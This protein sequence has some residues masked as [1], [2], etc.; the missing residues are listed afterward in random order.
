[1]YAYRLGMK[2]LVNDVE[3]QGWSHLFSWSI[4]VLS[5]K[6][7]REVYYNKEVTKDGS[8]NSIVNGLLF[9]LSE[10]RLSQL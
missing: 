5:E 4:P 10:D 9:N 2:E 1:M 8:I 6:V 3:I 7:V